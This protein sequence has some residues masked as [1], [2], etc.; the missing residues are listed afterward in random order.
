[1]D[2]ANNRNTTATRTITL[3]TTAP[4]I[5]LLNNQS[6]KTYYANQTIQLYFRAADALTSVSG[7]WYMYNNGTADVNASAVAT[8]PLSANIN[9]T[10][11]GQK[12]ITFYANDS[13]NNLAST[14]ITIY[15]ITLQPTA[16]LITNNRSQIIDE[17]TTTNI[18]M[19]YNSTLQNISISSAV[20]SNQSSTLDLTQLLESGAVSLGAN[21]FILERQSTTRNYS[22]VIPAN[23]NVSG[24]SAW[25]GTITLPI[26]NSSTFT[27]PGSGTGVVAIDVGS[28]GELNFTSAVKVV[29][30]GQTGKTGAWARGSTTLTN[31]T[32]ICNSGNATNT[33]APGN[34]NA[35]TT[36]ECYINDGSNLNIWTYHFTTF[37]AFTPPAVATATT[38]TTSES[39]GGGTAVLSFW[40][41]TYLYNDKEFSAMPALSREIPLKGRVV[42]K[43]GG[44]EHSA[45]VVA[46]T[47]TTA[48]INVSSA[49][50]QATLA[51][52]ESKKFEVT[53]DSYYDIKVTLNSIAN[54][55]AKLTIEYLHEIKAAEA[56]KGKEAKPGE[57]KAGETAKTGE[58]K[59]GE[60]TEKSSKWY[61]W[62]LLIIV[63]ALIIWMIIRSL[64]KRRY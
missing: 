45:G 40:T 25:A 42:V 19:A 2:R 61:L 26:V 5:T 28:S 10:S 52:G 56:E 60:T 49:P 14:T 21:Q 33:T 43:I 8:N 15:N 32:T 53:N 23:T 27:A 18:V 3:D 1:V 20:A 16:T 63:V 47:A 29:L 39:G 46:L 44:Q 31:I 9:Y 62:V 36:R 50:Q 38:T 41:S 7:L 37:A 30:G 55:K 34:I 12:N 51:V 58:G 24:G 64:K 13:T 57:G 48:T 17:N 6:N 4:V 22:V 35:I 54:S 11:S 59:A